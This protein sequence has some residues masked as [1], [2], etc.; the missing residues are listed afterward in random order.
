ML[1][2]RITSVSPSDSGPLATLPCRTFYRRLSYIKTQLLTYQRV[3]IEAIPSHYNAIVIGSIIGAV[4]VAVIVII[5]LV[6]IYRHG[7]TSRILGSFHKR[8][9]DKANMHDVELAE[10]AAHANCVLRQAEIEKQQEREQWQDAS[11]LVAGLYQSDRLV[12]SALPSRPQ[13]VDLEEEHRVNKVMPGHT[14]ASPKSKCSQTRNSLPAIAIGASKLQL[15]GK[16][17][18]RAEAKLY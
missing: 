5:A 4:T 14:Q 2:W 3:M 12:G 15:H 9:K 11:D 18:P 8:R 13:R 17:G 6:Y 10:A 1:A 16:G 7:G